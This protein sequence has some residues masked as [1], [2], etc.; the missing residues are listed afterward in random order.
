MNFTFAP[1]PRFYA[2]L[3]E[4]VIQRYL[5]GVA[6]AVEKTFIEGMRSPKSGQWYW[7]R[8]RWHQ[9]SAP[10]EYPAIDTGRLLG[11]LHSELTQRSAEI[12]TN[13]F[14]SKYLR[15]GT[16]R[17]ARRKMSDNAMQEGAPKARSLLKGYA[18]WSKT[19]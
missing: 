6:V 12:G 5:H 13:M 10:G 16:R 11:S 2:K 7:R 19:P 18:K 8:S 3:D 15:E 17:M 1:W 9:A 4:K 14:Y